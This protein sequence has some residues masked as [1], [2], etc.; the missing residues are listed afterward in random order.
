MINGGIGDK[1][2][3]LLINPNTMKPLIAP[4]ALD[5]LVS[6][7]QKRGYRVDLLDLAFCSEPRKAIADYLQDRR[8]DIIGITI[9]NTDDC[10]FASQ[11]FLIPRI[12]RIVGW[13]REF[14]KAPVVFG[15]CGFSVM[16]RQILDY[17][18]GDYGIKGDGERSFEKLARSLLNK[19]DPLDISGLVYRING[20]IRINEPDQPELIEYEASDRNA[21]DNLRYFSEGGQGSIE[22]K[23]GCNKGCI[24]CA[25]PIAKG[26]KIR[27]KAPAVV[28]EE[29]KK[30]YLQGVDC[31]HICDSEFNNPPEHAAAVCKAIIKSKLG[32]IIR[33]YTYASPKPFSE[34]I[35]QLMKEAGCAGID[36]GVDSG[37]NS[38]LRS[39]GRDFTVTDIMDA[40]EIC[41]KQ[42][43]PFMFDLL[44]GGPEETRATVAETI[45]LMKHITPTC[46]GISLGVRIYPGT[47]LAQK[48]EAEGYDEKNENLH[49]SIKG[50]NDLLR[51]VF[52]CSSN[53]GMTIGDE[54]E[55]MIGDDKRFF[56]AN[57]N[58][59]DRNYNYNDNEVLVDAVKNGYRGAYWDI[60]RRLNE[61]AQDMQSR[62]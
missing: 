32:R 33:W 10:Y 28:I 14:S 16:P 60:L 53:I 25:D 9:R 47:I 23:R 58:K 62:E 1:G 18:G 21:V 8:V 3:I 30:L 56:F 24:Y 49:G 44:I 34:S 4:I 59:R 5:Y 50:N 42:E 52:Y 11:E 43:I 15:G 39:L 40:A 2:N 51:P 20:E 26:R 13:I 48:V 6:F 41:H 29:L 12:K 22:T 7:L 37:N 35:A 17:C 19:A 61:K 55:E 36:F 27:V 38:I 45:S 46:V 54:L 31:L 57:P